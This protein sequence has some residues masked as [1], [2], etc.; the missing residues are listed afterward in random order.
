MTSLVAG[1]F[2]ECEVLDFNIEATNL[3][4][5]A[6]RRR[7]SRIWREVIEMNQKNYRDLK[8]QGRWNP[9]NDKTPQETA[10]AEIKGLKEMMN[11]LVQKGT[12]G[13]SSNDSQNQGNAWKKKVKC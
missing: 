11:K 10:L 8:S 5:K 1:T 13:N 7:S 6:N 4:T 2:L 9:Y 3:Y 12:T